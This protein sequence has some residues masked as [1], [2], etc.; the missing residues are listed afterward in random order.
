MNMRRAQPSIEVPNATEDRPS[1]VK[2]GIIAAL[3]FVIG[4]AW[5]RL[6]G[7]HLGPAA[8]VEASPSS[9]SSP[10]AHVEAPVQSAIAAAAPPSSPG[11]SP[12]PS[13][14]TAAPP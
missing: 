14:P 1:W 2:V 9:P 6:A 7:V 10:P 12:E 3:G 13:A 8:P 5:P 4:V 11:P